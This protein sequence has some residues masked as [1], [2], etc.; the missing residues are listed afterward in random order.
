MMEAMQV[1]ELIRNRRSTRAYSEKPLPAEALQALFEAARW[2]PSAMNEQPWR[3]V[4]ADKEQ[5]P[6]AYQAMLASLAEGNR[7]WA[8]HAPVLLLT[9]AKMNFGDTENAYAHAWHDVGLATGNLLAQATELGLYVH[10]MGGF[11]AAKAIESLHLPAGYQP[12]LMAT[13]GYLGDIE[14]L[15]DNL[16]AREVAPRIRKPLSEV[17]YAGSWGNNAFTIEGKTNEQ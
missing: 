11:S 6:E 16:K 2:A 13:I 4:Y 5:Q 3:F 8:Q 7:I 1:H 17:V 10:L 9:V 14:Q 12:V 15:P